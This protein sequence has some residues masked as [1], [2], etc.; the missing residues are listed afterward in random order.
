MLYKYRNNYEKITMGLLSLIPDLEN[1]DHLKIELK[2]YN[3]NEHLLFLW[4][5]NKNDDFNGV[6]G[7]Q[8]IDNMIFIRYISFNPSN[9]SNNNINNILNDLHNL[10][11]KKKIVGTIELTP[12]I[13]NWEKTQK[14]LLK[15]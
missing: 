14:K 4:K 12:K 5:K 2:L 1:V 11:P 13:L 15:N 3:D 10:Y 7:I 8:F 6:I 9:K